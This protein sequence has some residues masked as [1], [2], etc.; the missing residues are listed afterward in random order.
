VLELLLQLLLPSLS[1]K[2]FLLM[3]QTKLSIKNHFLL[4]VRPSP[5]KGHSP[6]LNSTPD[7]D[8][9]ST[10]CSSKGIHSLS[11]STPDVLNA[12]T[13]CSSKQRKS[14][15]FVGMVRLMCTLNAG[16]N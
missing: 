2:V 10:H 16:T 12:S 9:A 6:S 8:N 3:S 14:K 11:T 13:H 1:V 7:L 15:V 5:G 4:A